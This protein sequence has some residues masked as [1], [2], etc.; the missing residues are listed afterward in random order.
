MQPL[1]CGN[2]AVVANTKT[3]LDPQMIA[4]KLLF[5]NPMKAPLHPLTNTGTEQTQ[6]LLKVK[7]MNTTNRQYINSCIDTWVHCENLLLTLHNHRTSFSKRTLQ[8]VDE[9]AHICLGT[10]E[11]IKQQTQNLAKVA[12]LC[13][14]ICEECAELCER[15]EQ[16][17]F[18]ACALSCRECSK[19]FAGLAASAA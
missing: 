18:Q 8:V 12:L 5:L 3:C 14:G 10:L 2:P 17:D 11:A 7:S 1:Y 4:P 9:C 16:N 6:R 15:Y 19:A 13:V